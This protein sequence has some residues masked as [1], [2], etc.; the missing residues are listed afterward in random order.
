[1]YTHTRITMCY[2]ML[3]EY[4]YIYIYTYTHIYLLTPA[5]SSLRRLANEPGG[6][7]GTAVGGRGRARATYYYYY[8][9][10]DHHYYHP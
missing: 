5:D 4:V 6:I 2:Y 1:M 9:K 3:S 10:Y 7:G 8:Y